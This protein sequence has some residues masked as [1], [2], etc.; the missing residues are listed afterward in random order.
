M[1]VRI[2]YEDAVIKDVMSK[3][4]CYDLLQI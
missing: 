2:N 4:Y 3:N 1:I